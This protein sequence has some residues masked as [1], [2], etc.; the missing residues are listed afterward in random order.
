MEM[1]GEG[2]LTRYGERWQLRFERSTA[3]PPEKVWRAITEPEQ[4]RAWFPD[5]MEGERRA[6]ARLHFVSREMEMSFEG[7]MLAYD[8]PS[9]M[10]FLWGTD[11]IRIEVRA[12]GAGSLVVLVDTFDEVGKAAR[13]CAGWHVCLDALAAHLDGRPRPPM[14]GWRQIHQRYIARLPA[15]ASTVGVPQEH[16]LAD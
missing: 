15:E 10:E 11:T 14:D 6:G 3:H 16:P 8:P 1:M 13:D 5:E 2:E 9:L 4:M 12:E 7:E